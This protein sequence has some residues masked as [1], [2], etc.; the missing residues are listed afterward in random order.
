MGFRFSRRVSILPGLKLNL[1]GSGVSLSA[2]VRGAHINL[3]PRGLY[4]SAGIPGTGLSYR[5]RLDSS[6]RSYDRP[7]VERRLSPRQWEAV[8]R[9]QEQEEKAKEA[10]QTIDDQWEQY[11]QML[12]FWK[13][14]PEIPNL[15]DFIQAQTQRPFES[16]Q[17]PPPEP[18]WPEEEAKCLNELTESVKTQAPYRMLPAMFAQNHAKTLFPAVW[19]ERQPEIQQRYQESLADYEQELKAAQAEWE[20]RET[21]RIAWLQR[22]TAGNLEEIKHTLTEIF[23][24]LQLPFQDATQCGLFFDTADLISVN[25]DLPE[26]EQVIL[27][28]RKRLLKNGEIREVARD[29]VER[30]RDY[31]DLVTG[32]CAFI[33]A[34]VFSYLP[35]C[36]IIRLAAYTQRPKARET[37]PIDTC[38]LDLKFTREELKSFN[39]ETTPM[40]PFLVHSGARFQ[41]AADYQLARIEPPSWLHHEDI[42]NAPVE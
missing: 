30:N 37:D 29:K 42:Q 28:T 23:T 8:Q 24:G 34:E 27:F 14:L 18:V 4:G 31:F 26:M 36:Q 41:M 33:A 39:P 1:S 12:H 17:Q 13:P 35:L 16:T 11:Q 38:I 20:A 9:R 15:E 6:S 22:L 5:Q 25:L 21:E 32:E 2:G 19:Q 7:S 10:Q 40:H 3:G